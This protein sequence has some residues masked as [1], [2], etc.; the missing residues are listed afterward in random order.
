L[1]FSLF[2]FVLVLMSPTI[3][4]LGWH[5]IHGEAVE[6][7]GPTVFVPLGWTADHEEFKSLLLTKL[8]RTAIPDLKVNGMITIDWSIPR[9][10]EKTSEIYRNWEDTYWTFADP[11]AVVTGP[12]RTGSGTHET[13]C[14]ES[15]F[16][17]DPKRASARCL[18][19]QG[20]WAA[21]F[22]GDKSDLRTFFTI[23]QK[24]N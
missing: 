3:F 14:M 21:T 20:K 4:T 24:L 13:F 15:S 16:P 23:I 22:S 7:T 12:V 19:Q 6:T 8:S 1:A 17:R 2:A 18:I 5:L 9:P 10:H 11:G